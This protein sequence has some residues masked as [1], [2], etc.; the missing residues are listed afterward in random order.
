MSG[1]PS[2]WERRTS[3]YVWGRPA[4][5]LAITYDHPAETGLIKPDSEV[6]TITV[7]PAFGADH[8]K[9]EAVRRSNRAWLGPWEATLPAGSNEILPTAGEYRRRLERQMQHSEALVMVI[10][11]DGDVAG[12]VSIA[13]I[14]HGAM[15]QGNL[16]YWIGEKWARQGIVSLAVAT[17]IDLV[18]GEL[19]LHRLEINVR[20]ENDAS[21]AVC[22]KLGLRREGLRVR[23]MSIAG[24]W[25]DHEGFAVDAEM[26]AANGGM[27]ETRILQRGE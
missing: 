8:Q 17:V 12:L 11:V 26:L 22:K 3:P 25:S 27:V 5:D 18:I 23:Y 14:Q 24:K 19:G 16:G 20:P 13:G 10:E 9:L 7:R 6:D 15:S 2:W 1:N 4:A 21:L